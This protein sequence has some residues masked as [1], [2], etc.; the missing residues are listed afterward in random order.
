MGGE[1]FQGMGSGDGV[2]LV[3]DE[4]DFRRGDLCEIGALGEPKAEK[5][6]FAQYNG[7]RKRA[8]GRTSVRPKS[9]IA[10]SPTTKGFLLD[11][12]FPSPST[13]SIQFY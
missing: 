9:P 5:A 10:L 11:V 8:G 2:D 13:R 1:S 6:L 12:P 3:L 7:S 4:V